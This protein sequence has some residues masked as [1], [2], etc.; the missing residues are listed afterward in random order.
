[1]DRSG[2]FDEVKL[3]GRLI[4]GC[5]DDREKQRTLLAVMEAASRDRSAVVATGLCR[6]DDLRFIMQVYEA[7]EVGQGAVFFAGD[8]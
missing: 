8:L 7:I 3:D 1:M 6:Q 4:A 2:P 5:A